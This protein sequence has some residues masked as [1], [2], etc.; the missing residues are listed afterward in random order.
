MSTK[1]KAKV[2]STLLG[3]AFNDGI[4]ASVSIS[5]LSAYDLLR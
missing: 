1:M 5:K 2:N 3:I 4:G